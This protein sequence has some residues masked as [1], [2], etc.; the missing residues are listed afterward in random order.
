M[1]TVA[2]AASSVPELA[3][4]IADPSPEVRV[5]IV[6]ALADQDERAALGHL[7]DALGDPDPQVVLVAIETLERL[8]SR[9]LAHR[10]I[11][12]LDAESLREPASRLLAG[13]GPSITD[14]LVASLPGRALESRRRIGDLLAR[15]EGAETFRLRLSSIDRD[16]RSAA[17]DVLAAIGGL[18]LIESMVQ[19]LSD[20]DERIRLQSLTYLGEIGPN[21]ARAR[22]RALDG[23]ERPLRRGPPTRG[24]D[25]RRDSPSPSSPRSHRPGLRSGRSISPP[26][27]RLVFRPGRNVTR[28]DPIG[29]FSGR[30]SGVQS[31]D[32]G[33]HNAG[34]GDRAPAARTR[35]SASASSTTRSRSERCCAMR[36]AACWRSR[37]SA[38]RTPS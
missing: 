26:P 28:C 21:Q 25:P 20:P 8:R 34:I 30:S 5:Q 33:E 23:G 13:M 10:L 18:G 24:R 6:R 1:L 4:S 38:T 31:P 36:S 16:E 14:L 19:A 12:A 37:T 2:G 27:A 11:D 22:C 32:H 15:I 9:A 3:R 35:S 17:V 29:G 7:V